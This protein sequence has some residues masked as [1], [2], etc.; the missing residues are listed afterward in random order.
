MIDI[1]QKNK[2]FLLKRQG[3][4]NRKI[5]LKLNLSKNTVN[6]YVNEMK[7]LMTLIEK[8]TDK[9]EILRLQEKL[10]GTPKRKGVSVRRVFTGR[11]KERFYELI[12]EEE[13]KHQ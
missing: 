7:Q 8:E 3:F 2:I 12:E 13:I 5:A 4:S 10:V 1:Y 6:K 9:T 11:L